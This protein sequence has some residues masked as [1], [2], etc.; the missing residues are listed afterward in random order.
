[1]AAR[2]DEVRGIV[3]S[4]PNRAEGSVMIEHDDISWKKVS[5]PNPMPCWIFSAYSIQTRNP[6][7]GA[8]GRKDRRCEAR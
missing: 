2:T 4:A 1:M 6:P 3:R 5:L 8:V 7:R